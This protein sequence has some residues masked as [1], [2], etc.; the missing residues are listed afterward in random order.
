MLGDSS[1]YILFCIFST[2]RADKD[3]IMVILVCVHFLLPLGKQGRLVPLYRRTSSIFVE[4]ESH[5]IRFFKIFI[6]IYIF[7]NIL[8]D[9]NRVEIPNILICPKT[10]MVNLV[11]QSYRKT[12]THIFNFH[13]WHNFVVGKKA[14]FILFGVYI[15]CLM[16][17][18]ACCIFFFFV[19]I[20]LGFFLDKK[21][22]M[23]TNV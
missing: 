8:F 22:T 14:F 10:F 13:F 15:Q 9:C 11:F 21:N 2:T 5:L 3:K 16:A 6:Y 4:T 12:I 19:T 7:I 17:F 20:V 18:V 1:A 23:Q